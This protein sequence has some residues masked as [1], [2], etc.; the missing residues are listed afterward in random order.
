MVLPFFAIYERKSLI[1]NDLTMC[2]FVDV[3]V[4]RK[5]PSYTVHCRTLTRSIRD[6]TLI[7]NLTTNNSEFTMNTPPV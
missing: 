7:T 2:T 3:V 5:I 1:I 6:T 4:Y